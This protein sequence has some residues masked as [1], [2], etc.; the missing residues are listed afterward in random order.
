M[1]FPGL[2]VFLFIGFLSVSL[3]LFSAILDRRIIL[4]SAIC[5]VTL[6]L[7]FRYNWG[8]DYPNYRIDF[9]NV[10][11]GGVMYLFAFNSP[12]DFFLQQYDIGWYALFGVFKYTSFPFFIASITVFE[13]IVIYYS[14]KKYIDTS[15]YWLAFFFFVFNYNILL[16]SV[17]I[18]RQ[19]F[20]QIL[21]LIATNIIDKRIKTSILLMILAVTIHLSA[22]YFVFVILL[23]YNIKR[24]IS[25]KIFV[26][27]LC[28]FYLFAKYVPLSS[29]L[30][31]GNE[32]ID[33]YIA[34]DTDTVSVGLGTLL[35]T[36]IN[37][38]MVY[39]SKN[40]D[41]NDRLI[42]Y[43]SATSSFIYPLM[44]SFLLFQRLV[45]YHIMY[46]FLAIPLIFQ[47]PDVKQWVVICV[48]VCLSIF[49]FLGIYSFFTESV[50]SEGYSSY[51][52]I[53]SSNDI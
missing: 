32:K 8:T 47:K 20:A 44:G 24:P 14:I 26:L 21:I 28:L 49:Y 43:L 16:M 13:M 27:A 6:F 38:I 12:L 31:F 40:L 19:F 45:F 39:Y 22:F 30:S 7:A 15:W 17:T 4:R 9:N 37:I 36:I 48:F 53:F 23:I 1:E 5:I 51:Q 11:N 42:V 34:G 3:F 29:F 2:V 10:V 50:Y 46:S 41:K 25:I 18:I 35:L 33:E 52:T